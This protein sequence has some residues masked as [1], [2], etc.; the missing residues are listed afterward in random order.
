MVV[1]ED[2]LEN[3]ISENNRPSRSV[4]MGEADVQDFLDFRTFILA[5][6]PIK[7]VFAQDT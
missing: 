3:I 2:E 1:D 5:H 7:L 4:K 6:N